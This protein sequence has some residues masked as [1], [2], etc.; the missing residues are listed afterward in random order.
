M[1]PNSP[2]EDFS[3]AIYER[4]DEVDEDHK[5]LFRYTPQDTEP[6]KELH[7]SPRDLLSPD[8]MRLS[9]QIAPQSQFGDE[10]PR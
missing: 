4:E 7:I 3:Q 6:N 5:D 2:L 9:T 10:S 1:S 8:L